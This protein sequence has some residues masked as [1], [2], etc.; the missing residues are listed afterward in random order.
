MFSLGNQ[1]FARPVVMGGALVLA[2]VVGVALGM[3]FTA[4]TADAQAARTFSGG[5]GM[6]LN[7]IKADATSD[8]EGV[9]RKVAEALQQERESRAPP[10]GRG[11]EG[12]PRAG[13]PVKA[14]ACCT[15][16]SSTRRSLAPTT[17][18]RRS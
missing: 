16:G 2:L 13:S 17:L 14:A 9:M 10:A 4:T 11:L 5:T 6:M 15:S 3:T 8:F 1:R 18:Y 7:Y 12:L